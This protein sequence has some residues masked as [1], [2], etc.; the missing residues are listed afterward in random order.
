MPLVSIEVGGKKLGP[1]VREFELRM[2]ALALARAAGSKAKAAR[3]LGIGV[4][5]LN[6][7]I[8]GAKI[9]FDV[10]IE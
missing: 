6:R 9:S 4:T 10:V 2:I 5:Q 3:D 8:A 1:A 7:R